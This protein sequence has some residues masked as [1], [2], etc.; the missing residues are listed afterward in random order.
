MRVTGK[1][2]CGHIQYT[3]T[4]NDKLV[5]VCH[6]TSCQRHSGTAYGV[7]VG[8]VNDSF[9]IISGSLKSYESV[10]D[11]GSVRSRTF[12]PECGT[13]LYAETIGEGMSFVGLRVGTIDQRDLLKPNVQVWCRSAQSWALIDSIPK[14]E[15]QPAIDELVKHASD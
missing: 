13:R 15:K 14:Y 7:V 3:A 6:C 11:S 8:I 12:C 9:S 4:V 5:I 2:F 1:C 10:A